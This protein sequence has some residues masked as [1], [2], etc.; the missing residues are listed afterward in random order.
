MNR[1]KKIMREPLVHFLV[2]GAGLFL[3]YGVIN[4]PA[5]DKPNRIIVTPGQ[6]EQII[7]KFSLTWMRPP[8]EK[9]MAGLIEDYLRDEIY[10]REA[11]AMGLDRDDLLI[12]RRMRQKL[13]FILEDISAQT[14]PTEDDLTAFMLEH[15]DSYQLEPKVSFRQV[16]L[17]PDQRHDIK[18]DAGNM[19]A[20]LRAGAKPEK[21][22]DST[23]GGYEFEMATRSEIERRF[24]ESFARQVVK[25]EPGVWSGPFFSGL[26]G[27][28][29]M[30]SH[31]EDGRTTELDEV[32]TRVERDW[33][34]QQRKEL[35]DITFRKLLEGYEVVIEQPVK[36]ASGSRTAVAATL[37]GSGAR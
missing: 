15:M 33:M 28:L 24:G 9:E 29:V 22:G 5:G 8:N 26:G 3:L 23:M 1:I 25:L 31:R 21:L 35:K 7:A 36:P 6:V 12:R 14:E 4:G 34:A 11:T 17:N 10:F 32:R 27:H 2:I 20:E 16:Y 19:L 30:V 13:E 37:P 18:G